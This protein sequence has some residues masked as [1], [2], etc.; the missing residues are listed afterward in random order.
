MSFVIE[1]MYM[2]VPPTFSK[3]VDKTLRCTG[4]PLP[5]AKAEFAAGT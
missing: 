4:T 3:T 2:L 5:P 1:K